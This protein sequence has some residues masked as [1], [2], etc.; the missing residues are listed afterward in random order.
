MQTKF[1]EDISLIEQH[2]STRIM[3]STEESV[4]SYSKILLLNYNVIIKSACSTTSKAK[5]AIRDNSGISYYQ[6]GTRCIGILQNI[7]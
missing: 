7:I 1:S 4:L 3:Q 2:L 6:N 5:K